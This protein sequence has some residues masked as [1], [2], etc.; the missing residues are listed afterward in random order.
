LSNVLNKM[1]D[2]LNDQKNKLLKAKE[3]INLRRKF[4]ENIINNINTGIIYVDINGKV[5]LSNKNSKEIFDKKITKDF[6]DKHSNIKQI[7][8]K[9][10]L[11]KIKNNEIQIKYLANYKLK[12]LNIKISEIIEKNSVKGFILS[13]DDVSELVS[14]QKHAAWSNVARYMAHEIKNPLTPIKLSAQRLEKIFIENQVNKKSILDCTDTIKRQVNNIQ[15]LVSD[16]SNFARMP[17]SVFK[18]VKLSKIIETQIKTIQILDNKIKFIYKNKFKELLMK[19]DENQIGRVFL[20]ILK[21]SYES[22]EKKNKVISVQVYIEKK[23]IVINIED[24]GTGFPK[25]R[26][27][28]F[29]PYITNKINGTGL[30]LAVCK[31][32]IED[33]EGEINLLDSEEY[34][35]ACVRLKFIKV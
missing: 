22:S 6:L 24:N 25:N 3:I 1:L 4:T 2:I 27:K 16:F 7:I 13:I 5:L 19:C 26:D 30:G 29:E 10:N 12:F 20:N 32:I 17:E 14:A 15:T 23:L 8:K 11:D 35:G 21:N 9:F 31:K 33:H 18:E 28:L 34:G